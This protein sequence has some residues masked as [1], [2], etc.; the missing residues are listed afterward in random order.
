MEPNG[1]S[2]GSKSIKNLQIQLFAGRLRA[3]IIR[4][5]DIHVWPDHGDHFQARRLQNVG[6]S[7]PGYHQIET[8][9]I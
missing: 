1:I 7:A 6:P 8:Q 2:F 3:A 5:G 4:A 9:I